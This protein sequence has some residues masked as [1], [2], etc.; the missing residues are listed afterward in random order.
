MGIDQSQMPISNI[1]KDTL[2]KAKQALS[3]INLALTDIEKIRAK[4]FETG[5]KFD[6]SAHFDELHKEH[7][8]ISDLTSQFYKL[9]PMKET[10]Y[11]TVRPITQKHTLQ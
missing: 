3:N 11:W 8:K 2:N 7:L 1:K 10:T 6:P 9:V 5:V 4:Q